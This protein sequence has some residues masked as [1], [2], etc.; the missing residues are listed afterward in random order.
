MQKQ[1]ESGVV[2][3]LLQFLVVLA[4]SFVELIFRAD[5]SGNNAVSRDVSKGPR[6]AEPAGSHQAR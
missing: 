2:I 1:Q 4:A 5:Q 3:K 6:A